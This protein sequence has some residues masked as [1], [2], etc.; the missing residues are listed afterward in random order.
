MLGRRPNAD[1]IA[2]ELNIPVLQVEE[3]QRASRATLSLE[4]PLGLDGDSDDLTLGDEDHD[5]TLRDL[6]LGDALVDDLSLGPEALASR[7]LLVDELERAGL[8]LTE[9]FRRVSA[10]KVDWTVTMEDP[11]TW[12]KP[13][14]AAV[15]WNK[16]TVLYEYA[17]HED[18]IGMYGILAGKRADEKKGR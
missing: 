11:A 3:A 17:C 6:T 16:T 8:K 10:D 2:W 14:S 7:Q 9:R 5:W 18:N 4:K 13:W 15:T 12:T 1:E